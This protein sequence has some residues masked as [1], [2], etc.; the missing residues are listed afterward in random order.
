[1][2]GGGLS[3][4]W[5]WHGQSP[6][7]PVALRAWPA[8]HPTPERLSQ[9]H[10]AMRR[11]RQQGLLSI[12]AVFDNRQGKSFTSDG[13]RLWELTQWVPGMANYHQAPST[14]RLQSALRAVA[15]LH[16]A[17]HSANDASAQN[18]WL[19]CSSKDAT[20]LVASGGIAETHSTGPAVGP[21]PT[22]AERR[23]KLEFSLQRLQAWRR[24]T[25]G[26]GVYGSSTLTGSILADPQTSSAVLSA[27]AHLTLVH[28]AARGPELLKDLIEFQRVPVPLHF[29][30][31]DVWSD[32]I[33]FTEDR[34]T[35]IIDFGAARVDEPATDVARLLGSLEPLDDSRWLIGWQAYHAENPHVD[36]QRVRLLDRVGTLLAAVQWLQWL[37]TEP[38]QFDVPIAQLLSRWQRLLQRL[39][40]SAT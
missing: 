29:V 31:R 16:V 9:I 22:V 25:G 32:H 13:Q 10:S 36:V 19:N 7:G 12:P 2:I 18:L 15:K 6:R 17:W 28:L 40:A 14:Q 38:R 11:A 20:L 21:S 8:V 37:V 1:M 3:G 34:V 24:Q 33:L 39:D 4:A 35:G 27:L 26:S 5:I 23:Q 30:L